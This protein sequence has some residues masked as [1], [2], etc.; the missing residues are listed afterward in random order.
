MKREICQKQAYNICSWL[1]YIYISIKIKQE[2][3]PQPSTSQQKNEIMTRAHTNHNRKTND[4]NK[5]SQSSTS[6]NAKENRN[7]SAAIF[8]VKQ[9]KEECRLFLVWGFRPETFL[10]M[11]LKEKINEW[12]G[13]RDLSV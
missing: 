11:I 13:T 3:K 12:R 5:W 2:R 1:K 4:F 7:I 8:K 10:S 9:M 6:N